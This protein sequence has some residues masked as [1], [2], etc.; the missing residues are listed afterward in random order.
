MYSVFKYV[1]KPEV[2]LIMPEGAEI[3]SVGAQ[4]EEAVMWV[5]VDTDKEEEKRHFMVFDT[6]HPLPRDKVLEYVGTI[7]FMQGVSAGLV[8]HAFEVVKP[9]H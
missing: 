7:Q 9:F 8:F 3:L 6:G 5:H 1:L 2:T 4:G